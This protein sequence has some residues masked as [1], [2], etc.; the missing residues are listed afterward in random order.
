VFEWTQERGRWIIPDF[1]YFD[2]GYGKEQVWFAGAGAKLI[3]SRHVDLEQELY[4]TQE[5][6]RD[7]ENRRSLWI[8]PVLNMRFPA[9]L[10][11][12]VAAYPTLPL[13]RAQRWGYDVDRAKL[14]RTLSSHWQVGVGYAGGIDETRAWQSKPFLTTTRR[15]H[16]GNLEVW[17]QSIPGGSQAQVRYLLVQGEK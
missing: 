9:R 2:T 3:H 11:A 17:I 16:L 4:L 13:D 15:T 6:G 8:W 10:S 12:Q 5:A 14:E 1:G 7:S